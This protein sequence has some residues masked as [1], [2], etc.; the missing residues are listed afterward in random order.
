VFEAE[1]QQLEQTL[2]GFE[3]GV[4]AADVLRQ[5]EPAAGAHHAANLADGGAVA[6]DRAQ[7]ERA[8]DGVEALIGELERLGVADS[9]VGV[10]AGGGGLAAGEL[11]HLGGSA[12]CRSRGRCRG[13]SG[14]YVRS[15]RSRLS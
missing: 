14:G 13:S 2:R 10:A 1:K 5:D 12:R 8:G 7:G 11:E 9:Q 4:T 6:G 3:P 15:R